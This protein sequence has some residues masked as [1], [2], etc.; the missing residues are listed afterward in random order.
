[1]DR[2]EILL[3]KRQKLALGAA[4]KRLRQEMPA[5]LQGPQC[6]I[7]GDLDEVHGAQMVGAA[8]ADRRRRHIR[9]DDVGVAA[10]GLKQLAGGFVIEEVHL[11]DG[12]SRH[13]FDHQIVDADDTDVVGERAGAL[14]RHLAPAAGGRAQVDDELAGLEQA[15]AIVDLDHLVGGS[16]AI[17]LGPRLADIGVV[18]L[19]LEPAAGGNLQPALLLDL[20]GHAPAV[21]A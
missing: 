4:L 18:E 20:D 17:T 11:Q 8:M 5:R 19:P 2:D 15:V 6:E 21:A 3:Q 13:R 1:M 10:K 9:Q 12:R 14:H 7:G 16:R